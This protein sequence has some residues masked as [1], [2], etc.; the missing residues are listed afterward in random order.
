VF[1]R[2]LGAFRDPREKVVA[3]LSS[4][5]QKLETIEEIRDLF[6]RYAMTADTGD[7]RAWSELWSV[8]CVFEPHGYVRY[9][10]R[11]M[12]EANSDPNGI[13]KRDIEG[14]GS[15]HTTLPS[16]IQISGDS[17]WVEGS[18][19]VWIKDD[20]V[21]RPFTMTYCHW[22]LVRRDGRWQIKYR[23]TRPVAPD[24]AREVWTHW[25]SEP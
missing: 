15:L 7:S 24:N 5:L 1:E 19:T 25:K 2:L 9:G 16:I 21:Y 3:E 11:E 14:Q 4:R 8:D 23:K 20:E 13:H 17:A 6:S 10:R 12:F 22:D 18:A